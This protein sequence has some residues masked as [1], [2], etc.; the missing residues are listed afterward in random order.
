MLKP[1]KIIKHLIRHR[2]RDEQEYLDYLDQLEAMTGHPDVEVFLEAAQT[3]GLNKAKNVW[4]DLQSET[5]LYR[6][7]LRDEHDE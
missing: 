5:E 3:R 4:S 6:Q 7:L 1:K 2:Y